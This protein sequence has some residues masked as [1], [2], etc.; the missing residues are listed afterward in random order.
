LSGANTYSG[1]TAIS[2]GTLALGT[3]GSIANSP[4]I[5][6]N[7][8]GTL[9]ISSL[10]S[11]TFGSSQTLSNSASTATLKANG[12]TAT[13]SGTVLGLNYSSG[14]PSFNVNGGALTLNSATLLQI[15]N[16]G[17]A[18]ARGSYKLISVGNGGTV[19]GVPTSVSVGGNS[20]AN[21]TTP[22]AS[23]SG[24]ELYLIVPDAAPTIAGIVTNSVT[25]GLTFKIAITNLAALAG[26][27]DI[28]GDTLALSGVGP[29]SVLGKSITMDSNY[30]YY[31][32]A[33]TNE[34]SFTYTI[35]DGTLTANGTVYVEAVSAGGY[36]TQNYTTPPVI[37]GNGSVTLNLASVPGST[38]IVQW[39]T[40]L[41]S[42]IV[43]MSISTNVAGTN[44]LW[45]FT[46]APS[47]PSPSY[48]RT[49]RP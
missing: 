15:K 19:S 1:N 38:N 27:S 12:S 32:A 14:T 31:N 29:T 37:N 6:I 40:N 22:S 17:T 13:S 23:I 3:G 33:V 49:A 7:N 21:G 8:S 2:A 45:Q 4:R 41:S 26:W 39:T 24:N 10:S 44:G 36:Y 47:Q 20:I 48:Y 34:D 5:I 16:T 46:T 28:D 18:L 30:V 11:F 42:P 9:D 35:S 25:S 43:W